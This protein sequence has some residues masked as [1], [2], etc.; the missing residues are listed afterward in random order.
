MDGGIFA[1]TKC[2]AERPESR[3][4]SGL[5]R[6]LHGLADGRE[7]LPL[8]RFERAVD[9]GPGRRPVPATTKLLGQLRAIHTTPAAEAELVIAVRLLDED[10]GKFHP[11]DPE[12]EVDQVF[13]V[14]RHGPRFFKVGKTDMGMCHPPIEIGFGPG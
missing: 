7:N 6:C 4:R 12:R 1:L 2:P 13:S 14:A 11:F 3:F 10:D 5:D 8:G 9:P